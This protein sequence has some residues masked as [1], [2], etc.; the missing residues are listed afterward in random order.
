MSGRVV[1]NNMV[2]T[3]LIYV[4]SAVVLYEIIEHAVFPLIWYFIHRKQ[5]P[6]CGPEKMIGEIVLITKWENGNGQALYN[7]Q[8]WKSMS[9]EPLS[10]GDRAIISKIAGI[11]LVLTPLTEQDAEDEK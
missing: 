6:A 8:L 1:T 7:G 11:T 3:V 5:K 10:Q 2:K 9:Y 4:V